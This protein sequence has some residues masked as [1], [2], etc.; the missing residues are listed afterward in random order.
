MLMIDWLID[1]MS[2]ITVFSSDRQRNI[3]S[4]PPWLFGP[5]TQR[6]HH[7]LP[8]DQA[9]R[10]SH[11]LRTIKTPHIYPELDP[12]HVVWL[13]HFPSKNFHFSRLYWLLYI[14]HYSTLQ[15]SLYHHPQ[16]NGPPQKLTW[17][18]PLILPSLELPYQRE[19]VQNNSLMK[20]W[21]SLSVNTHCP[22]IGHLTVRVFATVCEQNM[23]SVKA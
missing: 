15:W 7:P 13:L 8:G 14:Y 23:D 1:L 6:P 9:R 16:W 18:S 21:I 12:F 19:I 22:V 2:L 10:S 11:L 3:T 17:C 4:P 5:C 20:T